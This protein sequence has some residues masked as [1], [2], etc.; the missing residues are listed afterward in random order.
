MKLA[1][2][3]LSLIGTAAAFVPAA[4]A[5][6][7]STLRM[8][9]GDVPLLEVKTKVPCFGAAPLIGEPVFVGENYWD[10]LTTEY[11]SEA[12]GTFIRA[13]ELK[14]GRSAMIATV[15][16]AFH[17]L[18]LTLNNIS[19]HEY[20]SVAKG[21]KFAD[22]QAMTPL[23]AMKSLPGES[24]AQMFGAIALVEIYELTHKDGKLA[25]DETVAPG[26]QPGGL[27]GDL[28][29][30]PLNVKIT[31]RRR[32]VE[33]QNGRAAMFAICAWVAADSIPGSVPLALPW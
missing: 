5:A 6:Q 28:G 11:G 30:N 1:L 9:E 3:L 23:E 8:S 17:K 25:E 20:L 33:L 7:T 10:K 19:P 21:I 4:P 16:Y 15:G 13:A 31:D 12:T 14:H 29:W 22:L 24:I 32:L 27:T 26:L 18:G 2:S